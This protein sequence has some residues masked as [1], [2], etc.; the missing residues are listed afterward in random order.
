MNEIIETSGNG[1]YRVRLEVDRDPSNPRTDQDCNLANVITPKGQRFIDVDKDGG[2]LQ[3]EWD[4]L[5]DFYDKDKAIRVFTRWARTFHGTTIAE[6][7]PNDG[8]WSLWYVMPDNLSET[9]ATAQEVIET[10]F[11]EYR[12]WAEGDVYGVIVEKSVEWASEDG[13]EATAWE[14]VDACWGCIGHEC[15]RSTA[16]ETFAPYAKENAK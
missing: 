1:M 4:R 14:T 11:G 7:R 6:K 9:T 5:F 3:D 2:P 15:A 13:D 12:A 8:A 10:E 16:R